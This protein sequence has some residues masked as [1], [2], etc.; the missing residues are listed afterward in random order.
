[1]TAAVALYQDLDLPEPWKAAKTTKP[2]PL[3]VYGAASKFIFPSLNHKLL[4]SKAAVGSFAIKLAQASNIHPIIAVASNISYVETLIDRSKGDA[5]VNY[6]HGDEAVVS[7]IKDALKNAGLSEVTHAFDAVSEHN[8]Y[9]NISK[10]LSNG[11][12]IS[13]V[14]EPEE[15]LPDYITAN[16]ISLGLAFATGM[17]PESLKAKSLR[18]FS[19]L[20]TRYFGRALGDGS[21]TPHPYEVVPGGLNGVELGL[22]NLKAGKASAVK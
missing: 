11:G 14:L 13:L 3:I 4:T 19:F 6:R 22:S 12:H 10:T 18:V 20:F 17:D 2:L 8:S 9:T 21:L 5:I 1:M 7:G 16:R 15:K